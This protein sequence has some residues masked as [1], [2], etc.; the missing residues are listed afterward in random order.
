MRQMT[1]SPHHVLG[2]L[3]VALLCCTLAQPAASQASV[4][5][6]KQTEQLAKPKA[7]SDDARVARERAKAEKQQ[8]AFDTKAANTTKSICSNC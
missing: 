1:A 4:E 8:K 7:A 3:A 2:A 5:R 6:G